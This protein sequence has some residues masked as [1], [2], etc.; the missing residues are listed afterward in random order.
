MA[1]RRR[2]VVW[3]DQALQMVDEVLDYIAM[4]SPEGARSVLDQTLA[5]A[6][7]LATLAARGRVVPEVD[8]PAVRE[9]FVF[10]YRLIYE[11][12]PSEVRILTFVH[13]AR[14]FTKWRTRE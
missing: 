13:G 11:V 5:A 14:D 1:R 3:T 8:D 12:A 4:D 7:S 6:S 2:R 9:V 10:N